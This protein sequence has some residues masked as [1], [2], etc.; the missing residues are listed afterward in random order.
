MLSSLPPE[1]EITD[2]VAAEAKA[3]ESI[4]EAIQ[5]AKSTRQTLRGLMASTVTISG[6]D[7]DE[8]EASSPRSGP[9]AEERPDSKQWEQ[10]STPSRT[11]GHAK[12]VEKLAIDLR[13]KE[14]QVTESERMEGEGGVKEA[15]SVAEHRA[16]KTRDDQLERSHS[17]KWVVQVVRYKK[18]SAD[19]RKAADVERCARRNLC[20]IAFE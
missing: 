12:L 3:N 5:Q 19:A 20:T 16:H 6:L 10:H 15:I 18:I 8:V 2:G 4:R 1:S 9:E 11:Q 13:R 17:D 7:C 14:E